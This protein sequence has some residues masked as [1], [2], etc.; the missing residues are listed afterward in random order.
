MKKFLTKYMVYM[1]LFAMLLTLIPS[2]QLRLASESR[3]KNVTISILYNDIRNKLAGDKLSTMLTRYK[4]A[5]IDTVSVME[6][7]L[8]AM[9]ARG[10]VTC[11]KYNVLRHKYDDESMQ[12]AEQIAQN[13]PSVEYD[14]YIIIAAREE[15]KTKLR[16]MLPRKF[17]SDE[18][19]D[20]GTYADLDIYVL[21]D[22]RRALWDYA[23]GY[24]EAV[25]E[26]LKS[27]G[28]NIA[29]VY[30]IKNYSELAYLEDIDRIVKKY[31]VAYLNIKSDFVDYQEEKI[32][33][34]NYK[35]IADIIQDNNMT[36]V[37]TE[38]T[39]QLSNQK[40]LGYAHIFEE[41]M[42]KEYGSKKVVRAY[43][44]YDDSQ[45][46]ETYYKYRTAQYFNST[47]DRNI[48]FITVTQVAPTSIPYEECADYTFHA[49]TEY[50]N[51]IENLGFTVNQAVNR[52]D[53]MANRRLASAACAVILLICLLLIG[54]MITGKTNAR[55]RLITLLASVAAFGVTFIMPNMLLGL[56]PSLF[57]VVQSSF[58]MTAMLRFV[59]SKKDALPYPLLLLGAVGVLLS[60]LLLG[61]V[62]MSSM[63]SGIDYYVNNDIFRGIKLSLIIPVFYTAVLYYFMFIKREN[64][65]LAQMIKK[66]FYSEIKVYWVL[67]GGAIFA[68]GFYYI[69]RSGNVNS[70]SGIEQALR[71]AVTE[72]FPARPRT[73][74]FLLGYPALMLFVYY[75]KN[76]DW[77]LVKWLLAVGASILAASVTNS[78][79]HV[80]TDFTVILS[81]TINGLLVGAV[82]CVFV[83][84]ANLVFLR[85]FEVVKEKFTHWAE[86]K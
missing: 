53:Y 9:I 46:D 52:L 13:C 56:Y 11:I 18:F 44:T 78:F 81:R 71:T 40:S 80:F 65:N 10:D 25:I 83:Y 49:V 63:L 22:G 69:L 24:D 51:K 42:K 67:I 57:C 77:Q 32:I 48:R 26:E 36:L 66:V 41:T 60:I 23:I 30:K 82:V 35:G 38:N 59:K 27:F 73:K 37:V 61:A 3:N 28:F 84:V 20:A 14:S 74:E 21:Y 12:I 43:E 19:A 8:N 45:V 17:N 75:M 76:S 2:M 62:C 29:L 34:E 5:G 58:A 4:E 72:I 1:L 39:N 16:Y 70:I 79:C 54:E 7:D 85:V 50:K 64:T 55:L 15:V 86:M 68:V 6:D 31:D 33:K 47:V